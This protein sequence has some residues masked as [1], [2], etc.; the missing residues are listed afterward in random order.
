MSIAFVANP[1]TGTAPVEVSIFDVAGRH[2]RTV[3][4]DRYTRGVHV[5]TWDGLDG[6]GARVASGHYFI[7]VTS[8]QTTETLKIVVLH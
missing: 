8:G 1:F 5:V 6:K 4:R 2:V 7:R 3:A